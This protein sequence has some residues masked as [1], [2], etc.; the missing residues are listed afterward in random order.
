MDADDFY[1]CS[2]SYTRD[3]FNYEFYAFFSVPGEYLR[4]VNTKMVNW[5]V[6]LQAILIGSSTCM[7]YNEYVDVEEVSDIFGLSNC[8]EGNFFF[9]DRFLSYV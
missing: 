1:F 4:I 2:V 6:I 8:I 7:N 5:L 3:V 9:C